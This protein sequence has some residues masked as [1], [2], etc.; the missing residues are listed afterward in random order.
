MKHEKLT[1]LLCRS[2]S[3]VGGRHVNR[4]ITLTLDE[5][6]TRGV[7]ALYTH[8]YRNAHRVLKMELL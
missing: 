4:Y 6:S 7:G 2:L 1:S 8:T 3:G 5:S